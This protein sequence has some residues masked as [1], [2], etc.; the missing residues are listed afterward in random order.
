MSRYLLK[1]SHSKRLFVEWLNL[2]AANYAIDAML[3]WADEDALCEHF[4]FLHSG[5]P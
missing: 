3:K 2:M 5:R 1:D 4:Y